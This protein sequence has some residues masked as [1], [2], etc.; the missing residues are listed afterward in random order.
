MLLLKILLTGNSTAVMA[1]IHT[2]RWTNVSDV[3]FRYETSFLS[4]EIAVPEEVVPLAVAALSQHFR[5][6]GIHVVWRKGGVVHA[7]GL[8]SLQG[9]LRP[10]IRVWVFVFFRNTAVAEARVS[11]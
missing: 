11:C 4:G 10:G 7:K 8:L 6:F 3:G 9:F 1:P 2:T 5:P